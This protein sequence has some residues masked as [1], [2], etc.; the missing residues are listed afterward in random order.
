[1][2]GSYVEQQTQPNTDVRIVT[3]F[4]EFAKIDKIPLGNVHRSISGGF[5]QQRA[6]VGGLVKKLD[7]PIG[8]SN[9]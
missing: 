8:K 1:M 7:A 9:I 6:D 4:G 5:R 3:P 2:R